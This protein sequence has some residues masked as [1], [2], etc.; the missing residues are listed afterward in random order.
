[1]VNNTTE[2]GSK[3]TLILDIL[4]NGQNPVSGEAIAAAAGISR[5]AVWKH[6]RMLKEAGYG[7]ESSP[8]GYRL[9]GDLADSVR[10]WEFGTRERFISYFE[11]TDSTMNRAREEAFSGAESGRVILA[12]KQSSGR[13]T[14]SKSWI[15]PEG[16]LFFTIIT[17]PA[18]SGAY[19]HRAVIACQCA[20]VETVRT[21]TGAPV[22]AG[23][24][25][26]VRTPE[27]KISGILAESFHSGNSIVF[28]NLGIGV[29]TG[30]K[31][32][33]EGLAAVNSGR[34]DVLAGFLELFKS[35]DAES[36]S[37]EARWAALCPDVGRK[38]YYTLDADGSPGS[39]MFTGID[40][41]GWA[42]LTDE[43]GTEKRFP[44][45]S[46]HIQHKGVS[47]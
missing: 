17:R 23:W 35:G 19:A 2:T 22:A 33:K 31:T 4:R 32:G 38:V 42:V 29:N 37:L 10:P 44:P 9:A 39:G 25:N 46:I 27:G 34:R 12:E 7:I 15:S 11:E 43:D 47:Q 26:D 41:A 21:L 6:I 18:L 45:G 24:P 14:G 28:Q 8:A 40:R 16:G 3:R 1:M 13:G 20:L 5:V 30:G 36:G